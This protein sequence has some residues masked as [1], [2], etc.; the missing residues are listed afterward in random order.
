M[1]HKTTDPEKKGII[2]TNTKSMETENTTQP[3]QTPDQT[4]E[5]TPVQTQEQTQEQ[6]QPQEG[7]KS[8]AKGLGMSVLNKATDAAKK[9]VSAGLESASGI[10]KEKGAEAIGNAKGIAWSLFKKTT[11]FKILVAFGVLLV[12]IIVLLIVLI[13][14]K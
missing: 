6:A 12:I 4:P 11:A 5:Q 10:V 9:T 13:F 1:Q 14:V 3:S 8:K 2:D 7:L